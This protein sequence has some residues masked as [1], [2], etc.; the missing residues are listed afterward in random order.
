[1]QAEQDKTRSERTHEEKSKMYLESEQQRI[2]LQKSL[3]R[4]ISK[5]K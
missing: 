2:T 3:K 1:M 5:S 4:S